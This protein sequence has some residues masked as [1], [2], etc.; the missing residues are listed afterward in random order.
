MSVEALWSVEFISSDNIFGTGIAVLEKILGGD[1]QYLY[2]GDYR[3]ENDA[4]SAHIAIT[5]YAGVGSPAF[6]DRGKRFSLVLFGTLA[7]QTFD[8]EGHEILY[9]GGHIDGA[10]QGKISMRLTRRAELP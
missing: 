1:N 10:L 2:I 5:H 4:F 8:A 3:V 7:D 6:R 9:A